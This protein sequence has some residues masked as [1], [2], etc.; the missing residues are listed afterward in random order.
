MYTFWTIFFNN[1]N[2]ELYTKT[3]NYYR[4]CLGNQ[5]SF[6]VGIYRGGYINSEYDWTDDGMKL[7]YYHK[8]RFGFQD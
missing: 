4:E 7:T 8:T 2:H 6:T 1:G 3:D 5:A